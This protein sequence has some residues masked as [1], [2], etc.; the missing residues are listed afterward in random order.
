MSESFGWF[1]IKFGESVDYGSLSFSRQH[2][3]NDDCLDCILVG[4]SDMHTHI[5]SSYS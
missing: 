5:S 3:S 1:S 2:L 4:H